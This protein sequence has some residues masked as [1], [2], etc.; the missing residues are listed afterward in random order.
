V[1]KRG[2]RRERRKKEKEKNTFT[3]CEQYSVIIS[4]I[5][6]RCTFLRKKK[7]KEPDVRLFC[8]IFSYS[9]S[10]SSQ[11]SKIDFWLE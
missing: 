10:I 3:P 4:S 2:G 11:C 9:K 8:E 5:V 6:A 7:K 1:S